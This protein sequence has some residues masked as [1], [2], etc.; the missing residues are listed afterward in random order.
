MSRN[1]GIEL[2][3]YSRKVREEGKEEEEFGN[4]FLVL[5]KM[6]LYQLRGLGESLHISN[7]MRVHLLKQS[8]LKEETRKTQ[9]EN[10]ALEVKALWGCQQNN[11]EGR[12]SIKAHRSEFFLN[13]C[14]LD[15]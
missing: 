13:G 3:C 9:V 14:P 7:N 10:L 2:H 1:E 12:N 6:K 4:D 8:S 15:K 5:H 11:L